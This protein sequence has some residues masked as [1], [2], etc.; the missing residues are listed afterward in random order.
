MMPTP[1]A[2]VP[3]DPDL[4]EDPQFLD[5]LILVTS[6][7]QT[8]I[9]RDVG[10]S[11]NVSAVVSAFSSLELVPEGYQP[12]GITK[13]SLPLNRTGF[14]YTAGGQPAAL[15]QLC[16][17]W[18]SAASHELIEMLCDPTGTK[19]VPAPSLADEADHG[20][21]QGIVAYVM[22]VCDPVEQ[23]SYKIGSVSVSDFV[24]PNFYGR[25]CAADSFT[26]YSFTGRVKEPL[27]L[28]EGGYITWSTHGPDAH[29]FQAVAQGGGDGPVAVGDLKFTDL[30]PAPKVLSRSW[31]DTKAEADADF[32]SRATE[33]CGKPES[34]VDRGDAAT[35][36]GAGLRRQL[37]R[38]FEARDAPESLDTLLKLVRALGRDKAFH[39]RFK[40]DPTGALSSLG[41]QPVP[42]E[43]PPAGT[44]AA[45]QL[46]E[47]PEY[48]KLQA[49]LEQQHRIGY[50]FKETESLLWTG[51]FPGV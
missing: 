19:T 43:F 18:S 6:A 11:W 2:L 20:A 4:G 15:I 27:T 22:E 1:V 38:A 44:A 47:Q 51:K 40:N 45:W 9:I 16:G 35:E 5:E 25:K 26:R 48:Q 28:L 39:T 31:V 21:D 23:S 10:P 42:T 14:H 8:Q 50:N 13:R 7:L 36:R 12:I 33:K 17:D 30:G 41:I 46:P 24:T 49:S 34:Y 32:K 29:V 3:Y 37:E